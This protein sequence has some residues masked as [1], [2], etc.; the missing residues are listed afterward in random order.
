MIELKQED[1]QEIIHVG[2]VQQAP[3]L[4]VIKII[5]FIMVMIVL[6][7]SPKQFMLAELQQKII[8]NQA[9]IHGLTPVIP[10]QFMGL[11]IIW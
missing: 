5:H 1:T 7:L 10:H 3:M 11:K 2:N 8:G 9:R 6:I 4:A